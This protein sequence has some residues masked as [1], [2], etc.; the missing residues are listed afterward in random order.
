VHEQSS[1]DAQPEWVASWGQLMR[2][3]RQV[4]GLSLSELAAVTGLSKGYL[5][6]LES[7]DV[8]ARNPSR[9][10][11]AAL[12]RALPSFRTLA[13]MLEPTDDRP[14][15]G[16]SFVP[17]QVPEVLVNAGGQAL[18]SPVRLGWREIEVAIAT[19]A[20]ERAAAVQPITWITLARALSRPRDEIEP[21]LEALVG[22]GVLQRRT[23]RQPGGLAAY[24]RS[25]DFR[26]RTGI[27][28]LVDALVL[29]AALLAQS[30]RLRPKRGDG[31]PA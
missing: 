29:A 30:P 16:L 24:T 2:T 17:P 9:A 19:L 22:M 12:A 11:L 5:S 6:K 20:L 1:A 31:G 28:Q 21:V 10:T 3:A 18:E 25:P 15:L 13:H 14:P 4:A 23:A 7:G 8:T 26:Q 27:R